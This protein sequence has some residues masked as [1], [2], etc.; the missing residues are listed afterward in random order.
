MQF[1]LHKIA[2][3]VLLHNIGAIFNAQKIAAI[4]SLHKIGA[5]ILWLCRGNCFTV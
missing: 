1:L 4:V 5:I 2:A 3:V